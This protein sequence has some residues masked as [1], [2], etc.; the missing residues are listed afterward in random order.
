MSRAGRVWRGAALPSGET[1]K[2]SLHE[3]LNFRADIPRP[4]STHHQ[5][6]SAPSLHRKTNSGLK[7]HPKERWELN[8]FL[9]VGASQAT[10]LGWV[11]NPFQ[12]TSDRLA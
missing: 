5:Q 4:N 12:N 6:K 9:A 11:K 2:L 7:P 10:V 8:H 1:A 3:K